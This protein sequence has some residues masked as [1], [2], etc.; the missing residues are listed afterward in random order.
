M[1]L[2]FIILL[3]IINLILLVSILNLRKKIHITN[4]QKKQEI[5]KSYQRTDHLMERSMM[6]L[7]N[8]IEA[9]DSWTS[10]HSKR[11]AAYAKQIAKRMG[12]S[13]E[14]QRNIFHAGLLHDIGKIRI[15]EK[16]IS[17]NGKLS[18]M[19][20]EYLKLHPVLSFSMLNG[21]SEDGQIEAAT[22]YHHEHYDGTG[23][24]EGL[25]GKAIPE[26]ARILAVADTYDAMTSNRSFRTLFPQ[27]FVRAEIE[28]QMG[29]QF[30]PEIAQIML[31]MIDDDKNFDLRQKDDIN[32]KILIVDDDAISIKLV[33]FM[34]DDDRTLKLT[35][36]KTGKK[37]L[38]ILDKN[39]FDLIILDVYLPDIDGFSIVDKIKDKCKTP[40]IFMSSDKNEETIVRARNNGINYYLIKPFLKQELTEALRAALRY[41]LE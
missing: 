3:L 20:F 5:E 19:E 26:F 17:K 2:S 6:A 31:D 13:E 16:I 9:K 30:D 29:K 23:Y 8:A 32:K 38:E 14:Y 4:E 33:E 39:T 36:V 12:K 1:Y 34:L 15:P 11:V 21:I 22:K 7:S 10:G 37:C 40:I 18:L 27:Q 35:S 28:Y 24:P 25:S 41:E